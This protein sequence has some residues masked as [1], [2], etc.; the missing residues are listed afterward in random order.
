MP[1]T[2]S[3]KNTL[4]ID[5]FKIQIMERPIAE[6]LNFEEFVGRSDAVY[7]STQGA[8]TDQKLKRKPLCIGLK[9]LDF[10]SCYGGVFLIDFW[11]TH[12]IAWISP[13]YL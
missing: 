10:K 6:C 3:L 5:I 11:L 7:K 4:K 2:Y 12:S 13:L 1:N 9:L 8:T